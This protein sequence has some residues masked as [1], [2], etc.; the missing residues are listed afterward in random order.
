MILWSCDGVVL[1]SLLGAADDITLGIDEG[2]EM[3]SMFSS[4]DGSNEGKLVGSFH[5]E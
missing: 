3:G 4:S 1:G 5:S 2:T